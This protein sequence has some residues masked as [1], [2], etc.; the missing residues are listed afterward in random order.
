[1]LLD[2]R[3][4]VG[5]G[6]DGAGDRARGDFRTSID[7]ALAVAMHLGI[8]A[9]KGQAHGGRL[10]MNAV[11]A[12]D[13][14]RILVLEGAGLQCCEYPVHIGEQQVGG[15]HEL[16]VE[17]GVEHVGGGHALM[18]ET[19]VGT[20]ELGKVGQEGDDVMLGDGLDLVDA[21]DVEG[22]AAALFPDRLGR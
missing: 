15:A 16:D 5:E 6:A 3:V 10:G 1:M 20:D 9:G 22:G 18:H 21:G 11:A 8:K 19:A 13:A 17:R 7:E 2:T 12:A 14:H 4:D